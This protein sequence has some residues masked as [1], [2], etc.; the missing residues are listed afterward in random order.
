[1]VRQTLEYRVVRG[2][3]GDLD[4]LFFT[5]HGGSSEQWRAAGSPANDHDRPGNAFSGARLSRCYA[6]LGRLE[7]LHGLREAGCRTGFSFSRWPDSAP[8]LMRCGMIEIVAT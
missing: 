7:V 8:R 2:H 3:A 6:S 1:M 5:H 4:G